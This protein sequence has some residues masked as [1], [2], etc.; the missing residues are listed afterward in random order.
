MYPLRRKNE[1]NKNSGSS[2]LTTP[3]HQKKKTSVEAHPGKGKSSPMKFFFGAKC[4]EFIHTIS[5]TGSQKSRAFKG[6]RWAEIQD[7]QT[8][9]NLGGEIGRMIT[10]LQRVYTSTDLQYII[11]VSHS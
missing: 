3:P 10:Q 5:T 2:I 8:H 7:Q 4:L 1:T 11:I 6:L 9:S